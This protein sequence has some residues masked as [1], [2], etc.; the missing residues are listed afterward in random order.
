MAT[1][2]FTVRPIAGEAAQPRVTFAGDCLDD[3]A[4]EFAKSKQM[5]LLTGCVEELIEY[6]ESVGGQIAIDEV[7]GDVIYPAV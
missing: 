2:G 6:I 1:Y 7:G 5:P 3:A 4:A